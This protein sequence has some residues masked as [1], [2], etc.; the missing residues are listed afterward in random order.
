[1]IHLGPY[2]EPTY[3]F[4]SRNKMK[5]FFT[6]KRKAFKLEPK[7][8]FLVIE[9]FFGSSKRPG[10]VPHE[11]NFLMKIQHETQKCEP[12]KI[13]GLTYSW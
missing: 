13:F 10:R 4:L 11:Q 5:I 7:K 8:F 6:E 9:K 2:F 1:M 3:K 12:K